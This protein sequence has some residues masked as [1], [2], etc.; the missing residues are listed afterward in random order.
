MTAST[1]A[2]TPDFEVS[3]APSSASRLRRTLAGNPAF[4][5]GLIGV[6]VIVTIAI[7]AP[8]LTSH[9]PSF[10]FRKEGR[11]PAGDPIGPNALFPLGTD[12]LGRD[13]LSRL[14]YGARVS[15]TI[16][17]VANLLA[18][19]IGVAV[20][21]VAAL[22]GNARLRFRIGR[23]RF[24]IRL[25]IENILMRLTDAVLSFPVVLLAIALVAILRPSVTLVTLVIAVVLWTPIARVVY[26]RAVVIREAEFVTAARAVGVG[27]LRILT[28]HV[29]PHLVSLIVV[30]ATLGI[31]STIQFEA[32]LSFLGVGVPTPTPSW[33]NMI[34]ENLGYYRT[35]PRLVVLPG[36]AIMATIL[37]FNL[38]GDALADAFDPRRWRD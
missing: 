11:T 26:A 12:L 34:S 6:I 21:S 28:R 22:S 7:L 5:I 38:L 32:A 31:A 20:G 36:L 16:G 2:L 18:T 37:A 25:P 23:R 3:L 24:S 1:G 8:V 17:L 29:M 10:A 9:D 4:W 27:P 15:L 14:L 30:Y 35:D 13:Y 19:A 33:G